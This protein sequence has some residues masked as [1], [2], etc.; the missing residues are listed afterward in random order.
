MIGVLVL[1]L[2]DGT[3]PH[4]FL[5]V[6]SIFAAKGLHGLVLAAAFKFGQN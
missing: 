1:V 4:A 5:S 2:G 3:L 6:Q